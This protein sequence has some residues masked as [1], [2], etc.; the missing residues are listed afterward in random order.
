VSAIFNADR[1]H[2]FILIRGYADVP[3]VLFIGL[4]PSDAAED[5]EDPTT[6]RLNNFVRAWGYD[7]WRIVNLSSYVS[8]DPGKLR[9]HQQDVVTLAQENWHLVQA[10]HDATLIVPCWGAGVHHL[11][12]EQAERRV[13]QVLTMCGGHEHKLRCLGRTT[14][15]HPRHPLFMRADT[16]LEAWCDLA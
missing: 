5:E 10:I 8:S 7:A 14:E 1:T 3:Y 4:N 12:K 15:G 6:T 16:Q 11:G 9:N 2:R 13:Q